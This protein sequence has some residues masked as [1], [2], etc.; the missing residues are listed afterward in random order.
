MYKEECKG[1]K[2]LLF[3]LQ[4]SACVLFRTQESGSAEEIRDIKRKLSTLH[5]DNRKY[6]LMAFLGV[7]PIL[8]SLSQGYNHKIK[9]E[10]LE[11][12]SFHKQHQS[13]LNH[14]KKL[15]P[16]ICFILFN[17]VGTQ[18]PMWL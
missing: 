17:H 6:F 8:P 15:V 7:A 2:D 11:G 13:L 18:W 4:N 1:V 12:F 9:S 10:A 16:H 3:S 5:K 14:L